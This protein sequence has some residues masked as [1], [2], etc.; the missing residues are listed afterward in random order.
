VLQ[1]F[2]RAWRDSGL[3]DRVVGR[4]RELVAA[5][6]H[7]G[8]NVRVLVTGGLQRLSASCMQARLGTNTDCSWHPCHS[9][10]D[11]AL[12]WLGSVNEAKEI[13]NAWHCCCRAQLGGRAGNVGGL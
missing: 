8:G 7:K 2:L 5:L 1:G 4:I 9:P 3:C 12:M 6:E 10:H 11:W 13:T